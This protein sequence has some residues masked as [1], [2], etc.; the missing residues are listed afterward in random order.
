MKVGNTSSTPGLF[1][2]WSHPDWWVDIQ[3]SRYWPHGIWNGPFLLESCAQCLGC[4][5]SLNLELSFCLNTFPLLSV[6]CLQ[7]KKKLQ[8]YSK[9]LYNASKY[10][11]AGLRKVSQ[12]QLVFIHASCLVMDLRYCF[13]T[14]RDLISNN[15]RVVSMTKQDMWV[16]G[17]Q[18][19]ALIWRSRSLQNGLLKRR[20]W[21]KKTPDWPPTCFQ[22]ASSRSE[23]VVV[24]YF[25]KW[26]FCYQRMNQLWMFCCPGASFMNL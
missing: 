16:S 18:I 12:R 9:V 2:H 20:C 3:A 25:S 11:N 10:L 26:M 23:C 7:R 24:A 5:S 4:K 17:R 22:P 15:N 13:Y 14:N 6:V 8:E 21:H 1:L 19:A